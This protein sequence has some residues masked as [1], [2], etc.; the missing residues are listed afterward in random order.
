MK[1]TQLF[2]IT[3]LLLTV[4][5]FALNCRH[6]VPIAPVSSTGG[7]STGG[8]GAGTGGSVSL[9]GNCNADSIYF[10][11]TIGP[12][13]LS[14]CATAG[15]HDAITHREGLNLTSY[16][17]IRA[18][19]TPGNPGASSL[20]NIV[21]GGGENRMPPSGP[22][23]ASQ[24]AQIQKWI[25]QGA[26]NNQCNSGCDTTVFTYSGAVSVIMSTYCVG[27]HNPNSLG[28]G[29]DLSTYS[30]VASAASGR[31]MGAI[32]QLSGYYAMPLGGN[33][34]PA[35]QITQIQKWINAG[36]LNN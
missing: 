25:Q 17:A 21:N 20:Y 35:C 24:I 3:G 2:I 22:L 16:N 7:G 32:N 6:D 1:K 12:M 36:M 23:T 4:S 33:K 31:L 8:S 9:A 14:N 19:V 29:I 18:M 10:G 11:N 13:I 28:G 27:C 26:L 15:C 34:L 5:F 30:G